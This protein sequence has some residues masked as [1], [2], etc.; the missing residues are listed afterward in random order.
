M[1]LDESEMNRFVHRILRASTASSV[2]SSAPSRQNT[3][4]VEQLVNQVKNAKLLYFGEFHSEPR[5]VSLQ[6]DLV[7]G[8]AKCLGVPSVV[9]P[10]RLHLIMEHFSVDMQELLDRFQ[11]L[12]KDD[13]EA[14]D[15]LLRSYKDDYGTEGHD[16]KPYRDLLQFCRHTT[17]SNNIISN[18]GGYCEVLLHGGFIPRDHAARLNKECPDDESKRLFFEEM[19]NQRGYLPK[20][21]DAMYNALF[22]KQS[23]S[24]YNLRGSRQ[25]R[26]LIQSL[27][28]GADLYSPTDTDGEGDDDVSVNDET[29]MSRLYQAQLLKD[30]TMGYR[31]ASL[32]LDH[33]TNEQHCDDRYL[34]IAGFGHIKHCLGVPDCVNGYLRQEA[35]GHSDEYR[36]AVALDLLV[37][38]S[39]PPIDTQQSGKLGGVGSTSIGCQMLYEAY[40]ELIEAL[41]ATNDDEEGADR[42]KHQMIK[43]I[44][45]QNPT[46]L[47]EYILKSDEVS[48]P[49][50][51]FADGIAGFENPCADYLFIYDEDDENIISD[52]DLIESHAHSTNDEGLKCP[53]HN[54]NDSTVNKDAKNETLEAY[55]QVGKTAGLKGNSARARAIM[56]VLGYTADDFD[57]LGDDVYNFQGVANPHN[58]AKIKSGETVLDIGS[59]LGID[60][61]LAMRD[62]GADKHSTST[63]NEQLR[64]PFVVGVDLAGSEVQHATTRAIDRGYTVPQ[65]IR[66]LRGD[67]EELDE[68]LSLGNMSAENVFD[69]CISNGAFCLVPNKVKAFQKVFK[70]LRSGGRCAI[71]TTTIVSDSLDPS[72]EWPVCMRMFASLESLRPML[73][74]IGFRNV[75][76]IDAESPMEGMEIPEDV[77]TTGKRFKIHGKY[78]DQYTFLEDK[79]MDEL[80]RVV[81]IY[82]E[83]ICDKIH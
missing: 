79:N 40:L 69:V 35:L 50:L 80:C 65:R 29:P 73:E 34:I 49:F 25:H 47:D 60:S 78:A 7:K 56:S 41:Q 81:T 13:D 58:V 11:G 63:T 19:S 75:Q 6:T 22:A 17:T 23:D 39:R 16:L 77:D 42:I 24:S 20:E 33:A 21:G 64:E 8:W 43:G 27:I 1:K 32:M 67:V 51:R 18:E 12:Q 44:Y 9:R 59:G 68:A 38:V 4:S 31:I 76:I 45:L 62:C 36:R 61:F 37:N 52:S 83:K 3:S 46:L 2:T 71:S 55:E 26:L 70:A 82:G 53:F 14:F 72:F 28:S 30:H 57:Y 5:I 74:S 10:K 54:Q 66:F 15:E 48:G